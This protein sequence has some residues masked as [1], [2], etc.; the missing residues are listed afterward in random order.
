MKLNLFVTGSNKMV[1]DVG[2]GSVAT[3]ATEPLVATQ[4]LDNAAWR[5]NSTVSV[6]YMLGKS[7]KTIKS[8][9]LAYAHA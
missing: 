8:V 4:T 9:N 2:R 5:M 1:D 3:S 6:Q 7:N